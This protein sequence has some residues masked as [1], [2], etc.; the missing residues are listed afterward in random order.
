MKALVLLRTEQTETET[1]GILLHEYKH[2]CYTLELPWVGNRTDLSCV[3]PGRYWMRPHISARHG[4][5][6]EVLS[7]PGRSGIL[8]HPGNTTRSTEGCILPGQKTGLLDGRPAVL[9]SRA[10]MTD[11]LEAWGDCVQGTLLISEDLLAQSHRV[12]D[13]R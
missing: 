3:P 7:V 9:E 6:L 12:I 10:A 2:L 4:R 1:R 5:T 11:I 8:I 13:W